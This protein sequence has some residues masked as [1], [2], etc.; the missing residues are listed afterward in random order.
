VIWACWIS[1]TNYDAARHRGEQLL[2]G[3]T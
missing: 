1:E 2:T 3:R